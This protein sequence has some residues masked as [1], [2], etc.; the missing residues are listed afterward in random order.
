MKYRSRT[1][2]IAT[3]LQGTVGGSTRTRLMYKACLSYAQVKEYVEFLQARALITVPDET[4]TLHL[5]EKGLNLLRLYNEIGEYISLG[6]KGVV[7]APQRDQHIEA[8]Q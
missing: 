5:T 3:I 7:H 8:L 1:D 2:I 6:E 4:Q